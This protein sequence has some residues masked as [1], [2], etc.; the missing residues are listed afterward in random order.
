MLIL[1][2]FR[3]SGT[4]MKCQVL[5]QMLDCGPSSEGTCSKVKSLAQ[6]LTFC[7]LLL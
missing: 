4:K 3:A 6:A 5:V 1:S 7:K 2:Q